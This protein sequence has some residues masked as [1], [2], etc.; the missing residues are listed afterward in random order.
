MREKKEHKLLLNDR[1]YNLVR[2]HQNFEKQTEM[3]FQKLKVLE[4]YMLV[5][6]GTVVNFQ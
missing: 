1:P 2:K 5:E 4:K 3:Q 6:I